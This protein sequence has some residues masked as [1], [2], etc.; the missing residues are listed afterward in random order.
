MICSFEKKGVKFKNLQLFF[1]KITNLLQFQNSEN[2]NIFFVKLDICHNFSL[3][4][5]RGQQQ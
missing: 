4:N 5:S 2:N 1:V 3:A